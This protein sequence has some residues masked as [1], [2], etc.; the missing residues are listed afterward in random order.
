[1]VTLGRLIHEMC[2][3]T[4]EHQASERGA[5]LTAELMRGA[6]TNWQELLGPY[7]PWVAEAV[8]WREID[9]N[10]IAQLA[11]RYLYDLNSFSLVH[12]TMYRHGV[13]KDLSRVRPLINLLLALHNNRLVRERC[14]MEANGIPCRPL[15]SFL[16]PAG[17]EVTRRAAFVQ[18]VLE[19]VNG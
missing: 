17:Y 10:V 7:Q 8:S 11:I 12:A 19:P 13:I 9:A 16:D 6:H 1:M 18:A 5:L 15:E 3:I 4:N 2:L 14:E